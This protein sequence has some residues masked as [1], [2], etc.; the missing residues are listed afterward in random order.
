MVDSVCVEEGGGD[1]D[2]VGEFV[3]HDWGRGDRLV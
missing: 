1:G 2:R 3:L